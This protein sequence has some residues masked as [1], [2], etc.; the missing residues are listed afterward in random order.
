MKSGWIEWKAGVGVAENARE[1]LP[2]MVGDFF[3]A[4][5]ALQTSE[6][7]PKNLHAFRLTAK[8]F[9]YTLELFEPV[10]GPELPGRLDRLKKLQNLLGSI[11]D[12]VESWT[13][14]RRMR[15]TGKKSLRAAVIRLVEGRAET[16]VRKFLAYWAD[17]F[18]R[19]GEEETWRRVLAEP[20]GLRPAEDSSEA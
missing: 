17:D 5:R 9:R 2:A 8:R 14:V 20:R 15:G 18:D 4:G 19:P 6:I 10:Y 1:F 12:C 11:N 7:R 13:L 3:A 16:R